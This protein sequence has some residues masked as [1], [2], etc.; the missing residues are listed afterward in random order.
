M[1]YS[2]IESRIPK[3]SQRGAGGGSERSLGVEGMGDA[4]GGRGGGGG[5]WGGGGGNGVLLSSLKKR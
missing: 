3:E 1:L 4:R 2:S 5:G